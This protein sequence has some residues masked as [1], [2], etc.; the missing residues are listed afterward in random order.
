MI[1]YLHFAV[2]NEPVTQ[3][4][5]NDMITDLISQKVSSPRNHNFRLKKCQCYI[6]V[7]DKDCIRETS[8]KHSISEYNWKYCQCMRYI[9]FMS[10]A[11]FAVTELPNNELTSIH[12]LSLPPLLL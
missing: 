2:R 10:Y 12:T 4:T 3:N 9:R 11:L 7:I 6:V 1:Q 5:G 8:L